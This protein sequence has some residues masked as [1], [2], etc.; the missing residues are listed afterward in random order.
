VKAYEALAEAFRA[1]GTDAVF[2]LMGDATMHWIVAMTAR[3]ARLVSA[4]HE[5]AAVAMA[6]G[7]SRATGGVGVAA[8]TCGPGLTQIGTPLMVASR[9]RTPLVVLAGD[10]PVASSWHPQDMDQRRFVEACGAGF[11]PVRSAA[12]A[13]DDARAAFVRARQE[14]RPIVLDAPKDVQL[15]EF[16]WDWDYVPSSAVVPAGQRPRPEPAV[17]AAA[18]DRLVAAERPVVVAGRGAMR[19]GGRDA[20]LA[21]ATRIGALSA[22]TLLAKGWLDDDPFCVGIAGAFASAVAEELFTEADLVVAIGSSLNYYT[23]EGGLLFPGARYL[24]VDL[25]PVARDGARPDDLVVRGDAA[26]T[27]ELLVEALAG[28][29]HQRDGF[30]TDAT[31]ARLATPPPAIDVPSQPGRVD[32]RQAVA[33]IDRHLAG[34][35]ALAVVGIGHYWSFP[36]QHM[37]G[38]AGGFLFTHEFAA[39]GQSLAT[40][41]GAA[42]ARPDRTVVAFEGDASLMMHVQELETAARSG[43][44]LLLVVLDDG[45]LGAEL[46]ALEGAGIADVSGAVVAPPDLAAVARALGGEGAVATTVADVDAAMEAFAKCADR[47][48]LLDVRVSPDDLSEPYRKLYKGQANAA[49]HQGRPWS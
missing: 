44:R 37:R 35:D 34:L 22:T 3:G 5:A 47:P 31:R 12:T 14:R 48:F 25:E 33:A 20:V 42:V 6:D 29:G 23:T 30:R 27:T 19:S 36:I 7:W 11:Q 18:V 1:E 9:A 38:P 49:P 16:P 41:I 13:A 15:E 10:T 32:P 39:I 43:I 26:A 46:H 21:L 40:A 45:A 4:R 8:V 24:A 2:T 28:R 17:L